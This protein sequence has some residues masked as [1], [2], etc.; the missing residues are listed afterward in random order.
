MKEFPTING[1]HV[2]LRKL[3]AKDLDEYI[4]YVM[5]EKIRKQFNFNYTKET[6]A[7]RLNDL[8]QGHKESKSFVWAIAKKETDEFMGIVFINKY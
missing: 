8:V 7:E 3:K 1:K 2:V 6:A 5:D 4:E